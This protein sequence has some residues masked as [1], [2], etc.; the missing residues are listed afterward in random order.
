MNPSSITFPTMDKENPVSK[1][2]PS[3]H[4]TVSEEMEPQ[5]ESDN[6]DPDIPEDEPT[7]DTLTATP[8]VDISLVNVVA[9]LQACELPGTQQF[10]L[11]L[12]DISA[13]TPPDLSS[14]PED[15][16]D[17]TDVFNKAK[18]DTHLASQGHWNLAIVAT[19]TKIYIDKQRCGGVAVSSKSLSSLSWIII[20]SGQ[21]DIS[22]RQGSWKLQ[23]R[24]FKWLLLSFVV[25]ETVFSTERNF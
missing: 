11:N 15:Y 17:F 16:H 12:K 6:S 23:L 9:Y 25:H 22:H 20:A 19:G 1:P 3:M 14:I 18:A 24:P 2:R 21:R 10:T 13:C 7:P 8:K 4:T 5:P